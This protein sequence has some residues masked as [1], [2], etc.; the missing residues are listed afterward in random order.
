MVAVPIVGVVGLLDW[1]LW[2]SATAIFAACAVAWLAAM[3]VLAV[4][5]PSMPRKGFLPI[6]TAR[7]DRVYISLLGTGLV[8]VLFVILTDLPLPIGLV[9]AFVAWVVPVMRWG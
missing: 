1:M 5:F 2:T 3:A 9:I 4:I 7:G 6:A 8:M